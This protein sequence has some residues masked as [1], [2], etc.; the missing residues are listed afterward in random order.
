M[1]MMVERKMIQVEEL[2]LSG[3]DVG[4]IAARLKLTLPRALDY[5]QEVRAKLKNERAELLARY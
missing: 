4:E 3:A 1:S 5:V 2:Y